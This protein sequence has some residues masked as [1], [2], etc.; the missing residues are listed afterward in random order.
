VDFDGTV[1]ALEGLESQAVVVDA[2]V[3]GTTEDAGSLAS[4]GGALRRLR[5]D[6]EPSAAMAAS[7]GEEAIVFAVGNDDGHVLTL[8]ASRFIDATQDE[9]NGIKITTQD[10]RITVRK[11]RPWID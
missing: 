4:L 3:W 8:W 2:S 11:N 6:Y 1:A 9:V 7:V 5:S 10:G